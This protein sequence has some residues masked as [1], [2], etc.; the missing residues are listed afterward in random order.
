[1]PTNIPFNKA[2]QAGSQ[3]IQQEP[4]CCHAASVIQGERSPNAATRFR[5][6][7][8]VC[9][10]LVLLSV[11]S[12][13][14]SLSCNTLS[15]MNIIYHLYGSCSHVHAVRRDTYINVKD[16]LSAEVRGAG[17]G[18]HQ[19]TSALA[20]SQLP[21]ACRQPI[22][23]AASPSPETISEKPYHDVKKKKKKSP[24][25]AYLSTNMN[26]SCL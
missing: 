23:R 22:L 5:S 19:N 26:S 8:I 18:Q 1:M 7:F 25:S 3:V 12:P 11:F 16:E 24:I 13:D 15:N 20:H 9:L 2:L 17:S 14:W 6:T 21:R 4:G 10:V